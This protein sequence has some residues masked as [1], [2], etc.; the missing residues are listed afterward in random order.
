[1]KREW[2]CQNCGSTEKRDE[3]EL[4]P[5]WRWFGMAANLEGIFDRLETPLVCASCVKTVEIALDSGMRKQVKASPR[6]EVLMA[7]AVR[8]IAQALASVPVRT[9]SE[10]DEQFADR[11]NDWYLLSR[12]AVDEAGNH[13]WIRRIRGHIEGRKT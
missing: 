2:E 13:D 12:D 10:T 1:M 6:L 11:M 4:P 3:D 8:Q 7:V 5:G 9:P